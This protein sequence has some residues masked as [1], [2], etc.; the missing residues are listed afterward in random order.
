MARYKAN[1][2]LFCD[3]MWYMYENCRFRTIPFASYTLQQLGSMFNVDFEYTLDV[4][5]IDH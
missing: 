4:Y 3:F 2:M 5:D 1:K